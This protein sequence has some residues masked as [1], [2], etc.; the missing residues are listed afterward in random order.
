MRPSFTHQLFVSFA[1]ALWSGTV[2]SRQSSHSLWL[3]CLEAR[4]CHCCV[5]SSPRV[6]LAG[7]HPLSQAVARLFFASTVE[8]WSLEVSA[9]VVALRMWSLSLRGF[10][11]KFVFSRSP[12]DGGCTST[13]DFD[14]I[15][16]IRTN[17]ECGAEPVGLLRCPQ[18]VRPNLPVWWG[19]AFSCFECLPTIAGRPPEL[20]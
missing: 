2:L 6:C 12:R 7:V 15:Q 3:C 5:H 9:A 10:R 4:S 18:V 17:V 1:E 19:V 20:R 16:V 14:P 13:L 11:D 8:N